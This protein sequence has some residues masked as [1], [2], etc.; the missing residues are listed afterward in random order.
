MKHIS[1]FFLYYLPIA[2][3]W[4]GNTPLST[5][6]NNSTVIANVPCDPLDSL[7]LVTFF[8][9]VNG[10]PPC[11]STP[12]PDWPWDLSDNVCEWFGIT[13]NADGR[14]IEIELNNSGLTGPLPEDLT[15]LTE[16]QVLRL[17]DNCLTGSIPASFGGFSELYTLW[18]DGNEF[19]GSLPDELCGLTSLQSLFLDENNLTGT[20]PECFNNLDFLLTFDMFSNCFDSLPDLTG[21]NSLTT[22][23][24][25]VF[26]NKLTF[27]DILP[28][29]NDIGIHYNPQDSVCIELDTTVQTGT[30]FNLSLGI[31]SGI[32]TSSY[33]WYKNGAIFGTP[34]SANTLVFNPVTFADAGVYHCQVTNPGAPLLT[35]YSRAKTVNV[36]CGTSSF[37]FVETVCDGFEIEFGGV[38][39]NMSNPF[40]SN[41]FTGADQF[42]CDSTV[43]IDLTFATPPPTVLDTTICPGTGITING[44]V[45]DESND[46]G[47]ENF[48]TP[49][50][51]GCDSTVQV[52]LSFYPEAISNF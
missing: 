29:I 47:L 24:F 37:E 40:L 1:L 46:S 52:N 43:L 49:D 2:A 41:T 4:F 8:N 33:Q 20:V 17:S 26:E 6:T 15:L 31:D 28:N 12:N 19:V 42:G 34:T 13:L 39:Y 23:K 38:T 35:L 45:Y 30:T 51:F 14:V 36:V 50:Q 9:E 10:G 22:G 16:L 48:G 25:K 21:M 44:T 32:T 7:A 18:L 11:P 5:T 27:D 3:L